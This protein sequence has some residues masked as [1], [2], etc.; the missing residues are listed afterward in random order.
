MTTD[1]ATIAGEADVVLQALEK[2]APFLFGI[3]KFTPI[4]PEA[5]IAQPVATMILGSLDEA[6]K[7]IAAKNNGAALDVAFEMV[8]H[9]LPGHA[10]SD[11]LGPDAAPT[12]A[13]NDPT[14]VG[15]TA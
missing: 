15:A 10:N 6:A 4:G 3:L 9:M 7:A 8:K 11:A 5:A 2:Y 1:I 12:Q 13:A 14:P